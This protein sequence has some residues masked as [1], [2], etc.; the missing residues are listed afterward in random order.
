ML[1][2]E[3][4][5]FAGAALRLCSAQASVEMTKLTFVADDAATC[6]FVRINTTHQ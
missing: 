1:A 6:I 5:N 3:L 4:G 2:A